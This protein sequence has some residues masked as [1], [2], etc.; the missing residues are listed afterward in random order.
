VSL[1]GH[2][3]TTVDGK[4]FT[5]TSNSR[6]TSAS[7]FITFINNDKASGDVRINTG[8]PGSNVM[9]D[10]G[11]LGVCTSSFP[12]TNTKVNIVGTNPILGLQSG[13][14]VD[15][16]VGIQAYNAGMALGNLSGN[17]LN[18]TLFVNTSSGNVGIGTSS[19]ASK[20]HINGGNL[21][22][23]SSSTQLASFGTTSANSCFMDFNNSSSAGRLCVGVNGTDFGGGGYTNCGTIG[24]WSNTA[25]TFATNQQERMRISNDGNVGIG[26]SS[27]GSNVE[28]I[29]NSTS[30]N[31]NEY[32]SHALNICI[33]K[34][35]SNMSLYMGVDDSNKYGY[36][37]ATQYGEASRNVVIN[38]VTC[39]D[40]NGFIGL[41][42]L[43][44][45][46]PL[47]ITKNSG[48]G[49]WTSSGYYGS[50]NYWKNG[51]TTIS[52]DISAYINSYVVSKGFVAF[53]DKRIKTNIVDI[54]DDQA[55]S[56]LRQIQPKTYDYV[57]KIQRGNSNVIGFI[58]QEIKAILPK[59]VTITKD[60]IPNFYT[61]CVIST[62]D[63]SNIVLVTS[64]IDLSW[65]SLHDQSGNAFVDADG[66]AC[67]D[68]SGN[69]VFNVK[70]YDQSNNEITCKT[71]NVLDKRSFL[72]DVTSSK[73]MDASGS[74]NASG[75]LTLEKDGG[76]FLHGQEVDDFHNIDK[77][78]IFTV[79]TAAVQDIDRK[80]V[81]DE[82]KIAALE[83]Q[84]AS[85]DAR[86][87]ALE[88]AIAALLAAK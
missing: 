51:T 22:I 80:Q 14:G 18:N 47:H 69:K 3:T 27:P 5:S 9:V 12:G 52:N 32:D 37:N 23:N 57:D 29:A 19:P 67:S 28:I 20:L 4:R 34:N 74:A 24:T 49:T 60:Y 15:S 8:S 38:R 72:M 1:N 65:N 50:D 48:S 55:L 88:Q 79:V 58:A 59:A 71:T 33:G 82:A 7:T 63:A 77:S 43:S 39:V 70:L 6:F 64:P 11:N 86:I 68:A 16:M 25:L 41:G 78:A 87:A 66:N 44:P 17:N 21:T 31:S 56:I 54:D 45:G 13:G 46:Y 30:Y 36:I 75:N 62:T 2:I 53:S 84:V 10:N 85:Q 42:T 73:L 83:A 35:T 26:T 76:Y 61:R 40:G 81:L